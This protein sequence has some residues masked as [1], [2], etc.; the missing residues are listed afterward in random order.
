MIERKLVPHAAFIERFK[1]AVHE[2]A[3]TAFA[4]DLPKIIENLHRVERD[5]FQVAESDIELP[6]WV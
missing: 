4:D 6:S 3:H 2:L 5:L 1:N